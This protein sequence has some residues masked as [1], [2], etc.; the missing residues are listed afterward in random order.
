MFLNRQTDSEKIVGN[1]WN[2]Y[3]RKKKILHLLYQHNSLTGTN[4]A[5]KIGVSFPTALVLLNE[6]KDNSL[7]EVIGT[8]KSKGGRKPA[9]YSLKN[10]SILVVAC[11]LD[12]YE[13]KITVYNSH[14]KNLTPI[15]EFKANMNDDNITQI[16]LNKVNELLEENNIDQEKVFALGLTMPGLIDSEKGINYTIV[17]RKFQNIKERLEEKFDGIVYVNNDARMQAYGEYIFGKAKNHK[18]AIIVSW[19]WGLGLGM[20]LDGNLYN[21]TTGFAGEFSHTRFVE[22]GELCVCGKRGCLETVTSVS[23]LLK[24]AQA[25]IEKGKISQLTKLFKNKIDEL[26]PEDIIKAAKNGD[27]FSISLLN[28]VGL[29]LG[30]ALSV[31]IQLLNPDIIVLGGIISEANQYVLT[32]IQQS[33]NKYCLEQISENTKIVISEIWEQSGLLGVTAILFQKLF[34]DM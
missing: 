1:E 18:N 12:R 27:E 28:E 5:K 29:A 3:R 20:I 2:K 16:I 22:N 19:H 33:L 17:N 31:T 8:G 4:I 15:V 13:G 24:N 23:A 7:I 11:E 6:L 10:D 26:E 21:G 25:G 14:N 9:L 32:P 30:K 34:S